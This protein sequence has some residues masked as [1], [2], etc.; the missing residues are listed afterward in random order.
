MRK[1]LLTR[2]REESLSGRIRKIILERPELNIEKVDYLD[3]Y[4]NICDFLSY[5]DNLDEYDVVINTSGRTLSQSVLQHN[6]TD[7]TAVFEVNVLGA[8]TLT[9]E[10]ARARTSYNRINN[11]N[12]PSVII[13]I[14]STGSRTV[15][16]NCSAYCASKAALAHYINCAAYELKSENVYVV[17]VHPGNMIGTHMTQIV[18]N[19]LKTER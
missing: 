18:Q 19:S 14:G 7:A 2:V 15:F 10:Y 11:H 9:T 12:F 1:V 4:W 6:Q 16:T 5:P 8:M 13:H 3:K 17:G